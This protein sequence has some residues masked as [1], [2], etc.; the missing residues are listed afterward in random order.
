MD[1]DVDMDMNI[2]EA[3]IKELLELR[4][5]ASLKIA[6]RI[7][8][9]LKYVKATGYNTEI[10]WVGDT[11]LVIKVS[12]K[13]DDWLIIL[14]ECCKI[15]RLDEDDLTD[16]V[17]KEIASQIK[18]KHTGY[19]IADVVDGVKEYE[20]IIKRPPIEVCIAWCKEKEAKLNKLQEKEKRELQKCLVSLED[21]KKSIIAT[22]Q[23]KIG[24]LFI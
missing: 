24:R 8:E 21:N 3:E 4:W 20:R 15:T 22:I 6:K 10:N 19:S 5:E 11:N 17:Y 18:S 23:E 7:V 9:I 14:P 2:K 16:N 1:V 12:E 13:L